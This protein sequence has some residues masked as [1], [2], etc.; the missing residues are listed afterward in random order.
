MIFRPWF[1][2]LAVVAWLLLPIALSA[3]MDSRV[4][5]HVWLTIFDSGD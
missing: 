1:W 2:I 5:A 3:V 4:A